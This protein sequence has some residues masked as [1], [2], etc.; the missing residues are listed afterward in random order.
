MPARRGPVAPR[1]ADG[2]TGRQGERSTWR[3]LGGRLAAATSEEV[4][5]PMTDT[6]AVVLE[7]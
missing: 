7:G 3:G 1:A 6:T 5:L 2:T 4:V